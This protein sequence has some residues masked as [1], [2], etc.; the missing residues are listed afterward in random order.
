MTPPP[1][2]AVQMPGAHAP[3]RR[4]LG[5]SPELLVLAGGRVV[6][7][8]VSILSLRVITTFLPPA[9]AG[10]RFV[11]LSLTAFFALLLVNPV[12]MYLNRKTH[13]WI[14]DGT[15]FRKLNL[16][17]AFLAGVALLAFAVLAVLARTTGL[18]VQTTDLWLLVLAGGS[19]LI[20]TANVTVTT[21]LNMVNARVAFVVTGTATLLVG[22]AVSVALAVV[23]KATAEYWLLGV[24]IGQAA[25]LMAAYGVLARHVTARPASAGPP[26]GAWR[27]YIPLFTFAWPLSISV[28]LNWVQTQSYRFVLSERAGL[29]AL[30]LFATG[31][32][33]AAAV[34]AAVEALFNQYYMPVFYRHV[35]SGEADAVS[36]AWTTMMRYLMP[37]MTVVGAFLVAGAPYLLRLMVDDAFQGVEAYVMWGVAAELA[38][39][40][41]NGYALLAHGRMEM[42]A[43]LLPNLVGAGTA[44]G[45]VALLSRWMPPAAS[46]GIALAVAGVATL[47]ALHGHYTARLVLRL[48]WRL[49]G[50]TLLVSCPMLALGA[51]ARW[52]WQVPSLLQATATLG[53]LGLLLGAALL[54]VFHAIRTDDSAPPGAPPIAPTGA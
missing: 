2:G 42:R 28:G 46:V 8:A 31:Y 26:L 54:S 44:L 47:A 35:S 6:Q 45:G 22:L 21:L 19:L 43:L 49:T 36:A 16:L 38:R 41:G 39:V 5:V 52:L 13:A 25:V 24:L 53:A 17:W 9:E 10:R 34:V 3:M 48:P 18:G 50:L 7:M 51:G 20:G 29:E 12:G 1:E 15:I 33:V 40:M 4:R 23:G 11:L 32:T 27:T 37:L 14:D 30:G